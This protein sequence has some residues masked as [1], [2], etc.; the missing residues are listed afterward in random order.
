MTSVAKQRGLDVVLDVKYPPTTS[1]WTPI[2][3]Q[4]RAAHPDLVINDGTGIDPVNLL[5]AM[6]QLN[7]RPPMMFSLFPAPG[8]LLGLGATAEGLLSVSIFEPNR[9]TLAKM[10]PDVTNI[11]NDFKARAT[12]AK[13]PY[14]VFET[15]AAASWNAWQILTDAV[16]GAGTTD[17]KAMCDYLHKSG[18]DTTFSGH[19]TFDTK[20]HNFW[21]TTLA[22]KQ[23]QNKDWVTVWP[24]DRA[25]AK[26]QGP[27][28][29]S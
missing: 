13:V 7:Y 17:Q 24:T 25:A 27:A 8:P 29:G 28:A 6:K 2:A 3:S 10:G 20:D 11:V 26:L 22:I 15:Q 18:A 19:L 21:P 1:D 4:V 14:T 23:I 16:K 9:P 5:Q 12:A